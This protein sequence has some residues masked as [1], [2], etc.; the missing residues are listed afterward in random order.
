VDFPRA[1]RTSIGHRG[2]APG[3]N[4]NPR[5]ESCLGRRGPRSRSRNARS[6]VTERVP[7]SVCRNSSQTACCSCCH[8]TNH[9][10]LLVSVALANAGHRWLI[11]P[12]RI[13]GQC[14]A[15]DRGARALWQC[16]PATKLN[17]LK[18]FEATAASAISW[19]SPSS[20]AMHSRLG[21]WVRVLRDVRPE[22]LRPREGACAGLGEVFIPCGGPPAVAAAA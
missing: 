11:E 9:S 4:V 8:L 16:W 19:R 2:L 7:V 5:T 20:V 15:P 13:D 22:R 18:W 17:S 3:R 6:P 1:Y 12:W 10:L 21:S 14:R